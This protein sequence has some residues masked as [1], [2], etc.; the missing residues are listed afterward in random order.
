MRNLLPQFLSRCVAVLGSIMLTFVLASGAQAQ[1]F[2]VLHDFGVAAGDGNLPSSPLLKD[3]AGNLY[4]TTGFGG[5]HN[6]GTVFR[7]SPTGTGSFTETILYSF[8]GG[9]ADGAYPQGTLVRDSVGNLYGVTQNGGITGT[10]CGVTTPNPG[11]GV[12][13]R[14]HP[15]TTGGWAET[16]LHRFTGTDGGT[17]F[18]GLVQD[19][20]GNFYGA[21]SVGGS[22]GRGTVFKLSHTSTGWKEIVLHSFTGGADGA[23][24]MMFQTALTLDGLGNIYGSAY[25]GGSST[26][27]AGV[28]FE[29][30]PQTSGAW[31]EKILHTFQ[32]GADGSEPLTGV[33]LDKS[34][35]VYGTTLKGGTQ[36]GSGVVFKLTAA[37][38]YTKT[39]LHNFNAL[40]DP[41]RSNA[42]GVFFDANGNLFGTTEY[43]LYE[44]T[45]A[46]T[47]WT[48][49][50]LWDFD[51]EV[52][53]YAPA[54]MDAQGHIWGTT[55]V[56]GLAN[57]GIAWEFIP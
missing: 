19:S 6:W 7:L 35:N 34:G 3:S 5:A 30:I 26:V 2:Q 36:L 56:G 11:C 32:S 50:L 15:T 48:E 4:G 21:T 28:I 23:E 10:G 47:D 54:M 51:G 42:H 49:T 44:L 14:L 8:K 12:V 39:V 13:F 33:I 18:A 20:K 16:V 40:T 46:P 17:S 53:V 38:G 22:A 24:P 45:P 57:G 9:S 31:T 43:A 37:N 25:S 29:L 52:P 27:N 55:L 41:A 1:T